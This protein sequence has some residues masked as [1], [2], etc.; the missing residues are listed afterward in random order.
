MIAS[1]YPLYKHGLI[2]VKITEFVLYSL[3]LFLLYT[4]C[5]SKHSQTLY[6]WIFGLIYTFFDSKWFYSFQSVH[7][8]NTLKD[9]IIGKV[10]FKTYLCYQEYTSQQ[11][12]L[13]LVEVIFGCLGR[14]TSSAIE[15][16]ILFGCSGVV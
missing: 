15:A 7:T 1:L 10:Y 12:F 16:E 6:A 11:S 14:K 4:L 8:Q 9:L 3:N 5:N 2:L 13:Y